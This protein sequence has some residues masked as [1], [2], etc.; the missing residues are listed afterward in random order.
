M[1]KTIQPLSPGQLKTNHNES[2]IFAATV[3]SRMT[4][5]KGVHI[6]PGFTIAF[7]REW[8]ADAADAQGAERGNT[9]PQSSSLAHGHFNA[10]LVRRTVVSSGLIWSAS[11]CPACLSSRR[12]TPTIYFSNCSAVFLVLSNMPFLKSA[13]SFSVS[14]MVFKWL[15]YSASALSVENKILPF[16][17][18]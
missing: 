9:G 5:V 18:W 15:L 3:G 11:W 13:I 12:A 6:G 7:W 8:N 14:S 17:I 2:G 16:L 4:D 1:P 10:R